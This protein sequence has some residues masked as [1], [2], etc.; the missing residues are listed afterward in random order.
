[1]AGRFAR[2]LELA[3]ASWAVVQADKELMWLP[4]LS[5]LALL[6]LALALAAFA[7]LSTLQATLQGVYA[8]ALYRY[9]TDPTRPIT[10]FPQGLMQSAFAPKT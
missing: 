8:A 9:A 10:G 1:M 4:A 3:R 2:S 5:V 6:A 7:V